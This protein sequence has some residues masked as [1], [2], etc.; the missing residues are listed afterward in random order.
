MSA[1]DR[2]ATALGLRL[3]LIASAVTAVVAAAVVA[4]RAPAARSP[5]PALLGVASVTPPEEPIRAEA[6]VFRTSPAML[7]IEPTARRERSAHPR[8][9]A[10]VRYLRAYPG[11]PPRIPHPLTAD[12]FRT[13]ACKTCHER[14]GFSVRFSAYV[15]VTPHPERG[16]CLQ[17]HVGVDSVIGA[18]APDPNPNARCP[19]CHGASGGPPR[20]D[21][22]VTWPTTVWPQL[23]KLIADRDPPPIPHNLQ[24]RENCLT[25]HAGQAAVAEIRTTHPERA[26]CRQCHVAL[27]PAAGT[28]T[29]PVNDVAIATGDAP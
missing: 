19:M 27:D 24:F 1:P 3:Y 14:G 6:Q 12:E 9:L 23:P 13:D 11:A 25:C 7:A 26:N 28:F 29:R 20:P 18:P 8:T 16:I 17:C 21:A 15:P 2:H 4:K 10:T 22:R 5:A